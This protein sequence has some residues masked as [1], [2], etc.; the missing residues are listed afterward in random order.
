MALPTRSPADFFLPN[1]LDFAMSQNP[2]AAPLSND[3][4]PGMADSGGDVLADRGTRFVASFVDGLLIMAIVL[5]IGIATG[6]YARA[7]TQQVGFA[8]QVAMAALGAVA[9]LAVNGYLLANRGQTVGKMLNKIR[10]VDAQ[11]GSRLPFVRVFVYRSLWLIPLVVIAAFIPGQAD[12]ILI[13][14]VSLVDALFIFGKQRRC[15]HDYIAGSKVVR[16]IQP[17]TIPA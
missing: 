9:M 11:T 4:N 17:P 3:D 5:P 13:N 1:T 6:F 15:L 16:V 12:D 7:A 10:I 8:E 14:L 2:Y